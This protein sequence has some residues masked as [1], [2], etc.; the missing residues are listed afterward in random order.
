MRIVICEDE[1][2]YQ[3]SLKQAIGRWQRAS[4]HSDIEVLAYSS[5]ED[6]LEQVERKLEADLFFI[7]IQIPGELNGVDL[8]RKIRETDLDVT[9]VFCTNYSEYVY[10]GYTVNALRFLRKPV[11]PRDVFFCCEY[12]YKRSLV[13]NANT[14]TV[15]S[16][17]RRTVLRYAEIIFLETQG[18]SLYIR[19]TVAPEPIK[20]NARLSDVMAELPKE[21]FAFCHRSYAVNVAHIRMLTRTMCLLFNGES[22]PISRTYMNDV[23]QTFDRYHQGGVCEHGMDRI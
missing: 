18:H 22:L 2:V 15:V 12:A 3:A 19:S 21:L 17:G 11:D 6:L 8:A 1:P 16:A 5:S 4:G 20:L 9:I 14:L 7:D 23:T 10:E 13:S